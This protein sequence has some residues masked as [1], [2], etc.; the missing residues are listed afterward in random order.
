VVLVE[1]VAAVE[2]AALDKR[3][4][5]VGPVVLVEPVTADE[6]AV[7]DQPVVQVEPVTAPTSPRGPSISGWSWSGR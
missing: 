2:P 7:L 5:Q 4:V 1:L 6:R 3:A